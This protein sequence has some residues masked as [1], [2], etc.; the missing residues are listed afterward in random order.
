[1]KASL[2]ILEASSSTSLMLSKYFLAQSSIWGWLLSIV[3]YALISLFNVKIKLVIAAIIVAGLALISTYGLYKWSNHVSGLQP[4]DYTIITLS[5]IF[6][7]ILIIREAKN[8][9]PF[10]IPQTICTILF[11]SAF[12]LIGLKMEIGWY[13]MLLGHVNN[14]YL[15][16]KKSAY[17]VG[18][19]Q[20]VSLIIVLSKI[21]SFN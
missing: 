19:M 6:S 20:L 3:G 7:I 4:V 14:L 1:M 21:I 12:I 9:R 16:V 18:F 17:I 2:R 13:A 5:S 10:W 11:T 8:R 15:Y